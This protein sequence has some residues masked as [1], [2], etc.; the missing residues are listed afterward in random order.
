MYI[1]NF[2]KLIQYVLSQPDGLGVLILDVKLNCSVY[3]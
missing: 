1:I 2:I 3:R